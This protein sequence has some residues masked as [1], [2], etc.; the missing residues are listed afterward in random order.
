MA[1]RVAVAQR[2]IRLQGN[3]S[4]ELNQTIGVSGEIFFDATNQS[5]R[6]FPTGGTTSVLLST[7]SYVDTQIANLI[8]GAPSTLDTLAEIAT[9]LQ[10]QPALTA[11]LDAIATKANTSALS[12]VAF[13][14][15]YNS[16]SNKPDLAGK[17]ATLVSGTNIKTI[18]GSSLLGSGNLT[19]G[20]GSQAVGGSTGAIQFN[21]NGALGGNSNLRFD[22]V[23]TQ[24]IGYGVPLLTT[25]YSSLAGGI[26]NASG[27][28]RAGNVNT[29]G[30]PSTTAGFVRLRSQRTG[31]VPGGPS[32]QVPFYGFKAKDNQFASLTFEN[33]MMSSVAIVMGATAPYVANG[34]QGY[35]SFG[36]DGTV[37]GISGS[38]YGAP[39]LGRFTAG[40]GDE[41]WR[42]FLNLDGR[43]SLTIGGGITMAPPAWRPWFTAGKRDDPTGPAVECGITF[44]DG[45]FQN[46]ALSLTIKD[47]GTDVV[48]NAKAL[49]FVGAGVTTTNGSNGVAT[50]TIPRG[51]AVQEE[52]TNVVTGAGTINFVGAGV[53]ASDVS[54]V[55]TVTV[56]S[57][58][59][60]KDE[61]TNVVTS[62]T[63]IN[64]VGSGVTASDVSGVA[65]ITVTGGAEAAGNI[66]EVQY[67]NG[68]AT[69]GADPSFIYKNGGLFVGGIA[70]T[71]ATATGIVSANAEFRVGTWSLAGSL[72]GD[73]W[74]RIRMGQDAR[75]RT[76][77]YYG[78]DA[79]PTLNPMVGIPARTLVISNEELESKQAIVLM[80]AQTYPADP[81]S[82]GTVFG[83]SGIDLSYEN[84]YQPTT[85]TET[86]WH[87]FIDV[88]NTGNVKIG[89]SLVISPS[90]QP[91]P[92][93]NNE[94][95][96][97]FADG[98]FQY[99]AAAGAEIS[100]QEEGTDVVASASTINFVGAGVEAS[101]VGGVATVTIHG[102][103]TVFDQGF[104][105][106]ASITALDFVGS[107]VTTETTIGSGKATVTIPGGSGVATIYDAGS[108]STVTLNYNNGQWQRY[109]PNSGTLNITVTNIPPGGEMNIF[110][111]TG[112]TNTTVNWV[113]VIFW[114]GG[115]KTLSTQNGIRDVITIKND[116]YYT[117]GK[118]SKGYTS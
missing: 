2:S 19:I 74:G 42:T 79:D 23:R 45:T 92:P 118:V 91:T 85:G 97:Y 39:S 36:G 54:G 38:L 57:G 18:N 109:S 73:R 106:L 17:Q 114:E 99:T 16:L 48:T 35:D 98:T 11:I 29:N 103:I 93:A 87:K 15:S 24:T 22:G 68:N 100:V 59:L 101:D 52:G 115:V 1:T 53:T 110:I 43:G 107:G 8:N 7:K 112:G 95:G 28:V 64:F 76:D 56:P 96:I 55:A 69:F 116:G 65:T 75:V 60:V 61:G 83:V 104:P 113:G 94:V 78:F 105:I 27:E 10:N 90:F 111:Q 63:T 88:T 31:P 21:N 89:G 26:V 44:A 47:E 66:T 37:F 102:G 25:M 51:V 72:Y 86:G 41:Y 70:N 46:T 81:E 4:T 80:D 14:G 117:Y 58:I 6:I 40:D 13:S 82:E 108:N 34:V 50:V 12:D 71:T 3:T 84:S 33:D 49:N 67:N 30:V 20:G 9:A 77:P 32:A 62:A 5:L